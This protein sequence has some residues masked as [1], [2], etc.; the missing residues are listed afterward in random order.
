MDRILEVFQYISSTSSLTFK[1]NQIRRK[2]HFSQNA[3]SETAGKQQKQNVDDDALAARGA[4]NTT[5][6]SQVVLVVA[7]SSKKGKIERQIQT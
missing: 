6:T 1:V 2:Y 7:L 3:M 5:Q 4:A